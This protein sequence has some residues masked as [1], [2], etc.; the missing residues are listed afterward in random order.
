MTNAEKTAYLSQYRAIDRRIERLLDERR[1]WAARAA[2]VSATCSGMPNA[3]KRRGGGD[4]V[5]SCVE[6]M[7]LIEEEIDAQVTRLV[8]L[9]RTI[10]LYIETVPDERQRDLLRYRYIDGLTWERVADAMHYSTMQI[11]RLHAKAL[12]ALAL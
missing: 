8:C 2:A 9:R 4:W 10:E 1:E 6:R 11:S 7:L 12:A 5:S 3:S